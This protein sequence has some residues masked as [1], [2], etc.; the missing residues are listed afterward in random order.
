MAP[1]CPRLS[2]S[3]DYSTLYGR[4]YFCFDLPESASFPRGKCVISTLSLFRRGSTLGK[5]N[6][7]ILRKIAFRSGP[8]FITIIMVQTKRARPEE[9]AGDGPRLP[10]PFKLERLFDIV[11][12]W[13]L[14]FRSPRIR[15]IPAWEM[16]HQHPHTRRISQGR[17]TQRAIA[18][19]D[20]A[21]EL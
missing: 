13:V 4:G 7:S 19:H 20:V 2:S 10:A 12:A 14:L 9:G 17:E 1:A 8:P 18:P 6:R 15:F 3:R 11:W 5:A 16:C 21:Y